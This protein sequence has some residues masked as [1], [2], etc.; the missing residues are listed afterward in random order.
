[1]NSEQQSTLENSSNARA[2]DP[3]QGEH[4]LSWSVFN[5]DLSQLEFFRRVLEEAMDETVPALE[6]LKF[7]AVL[8]S[9]L[10]E[11]FMV[12]VSG[13]KEMLGISG[14]GAMPG[15]LTPLLF[16]NEH[17]QAQLRRR[18]SLQT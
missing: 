10:D 13:L 18:H 2:R 4:L 9:N 11:F 1:M 17:W 3:F 6:R 14:L 8:I 15:E 12:R 5:R 7:L 16:A